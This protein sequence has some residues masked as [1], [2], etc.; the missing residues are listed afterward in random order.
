MQLMYCAEVSVAICNIDVLRLTLFC[1][2]MR[3]WVQL[4][5]RCR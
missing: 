1:V 2:G 4:I 5:L 3:I